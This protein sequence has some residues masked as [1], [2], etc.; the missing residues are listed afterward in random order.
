MQ[1]LR[2]IVST[3]ECVEARGER[4]LVVRREPCEDCAVVTLRGVSDENRGRTLQ[5]LTPF[6]RLRRWSAP[7]RVVRRPRRRVLERAARAVADAHGWLEPWTPTVADI[8]LHPWQLE[9]AIAALSGGMRLLLADEVGLGKTIQAGLVVVELQ[10]RGLSSR[11]LILTPASLRHQWAG[12]LHHR[13][14]LDPL[15]LDHEALTR[16]SAHLPVGVNPWT[17]A[18]LVISSI[19][20]VKRP[21]VRR[22]L[23]AAPVDI[24][25]VDEAHHLTPGTDRG[26]VVAQ[27]AERTP[28]VVLVTATPHSGDPEAFSYLSR[29]GS[30]GHQSSAVV[31]RRRAREV[32]LQRTRHVHL[33]RVRPSEPERA[34]L[35]A[36]L[37]YASALWRQRE[38][39]TRGPALVAAVICRRAVSSGR[40]LART[41]ARRRALLAGSIRDV[42]V[43]PAL[44]WLEEDPADAVESDSLLGACALADRRD[45][46]DWLN[47]L[48]ALAERLE[49]TSK[50]EAI[51]RILERSDE[52]ALV[53]SEYRDTLCQLAERLSHRWP[54]SMLHGGLSARE[55]RDAIRDFLTG[56]ARVLLATDAAGEGLN[57]QARCRLVINVELPWNPVRLE[58]RIGRVDRLGQHR[59]VHAVH[60]HYAD[61]FEEQVLAQLHRRAARAALDLQQSAFDDWTVAAAVFDGQPVALQ[62]SMAVSLTP[63]RG[64][65]GLHRAI[66]RRTAAQ[67]A[68]SASPTTTVF[69]GAPGRRQ[70]V[71]SM[72][73]LFKWEAHDDAGRLVACEVA[74]L[75]VTFT[76]P[77][78][79]PRRAVRQWTR[80]LAACPPV[81]AALSR[82]P[83]EG[84]RQ[85][86]SAAGNTAEAVAR[87]LREIEECLAA[88]RPHA[89]QGSLFDRRAEQRAAEDHAAVA[90]LHEHVRHQL[91]ST[92]ALRLVS[93]STP[94]RL[95]AAWP[96]S[97]E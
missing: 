85:V 97:Q 62:P 7:T 35:D 20:L 67:L 8:D 93:L 4:W 75:K 23:D 74:C 49:M 48:I 76:R 32:G 90:V 83:T 73:L 59:R 55:R 42:L 95:V 77:R 31:F 87:R 80:V 36:T 41:L 34:L 22:A 65:N 40:A 6:D 29:L 61:S 53:F 78:R 69:V 28:W 81:Q 11:A 37:A 47:R 52:P 43:Q 44:P 21:E 89:Y 45:E 27:L 17:T 92:R 66:D 51:V 54:V 57:L 71:R 70:L 16:L 24:L 58:Q 94:A 50:L 68:G 64:S 82:C 96:L 12:E 5:L 38:T 15:V 25:V 13:F 10:R 3:T 60:L 33:H 30:R 86:Q 14:S 2:S 84:L 88:R 9:P 79:L 56:R 91:S 26:T 19:D 1:K 63:S 39:G 72:A 46:L 18:D